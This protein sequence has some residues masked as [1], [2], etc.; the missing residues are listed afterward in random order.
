MASQWSEAPF[1]HTCD[2]CA[3]FVRDSELCVH[4]YPTHPHRKGALPIVF[5]KEFELA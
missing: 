5:C 3:H 2:D 1:L 4:G